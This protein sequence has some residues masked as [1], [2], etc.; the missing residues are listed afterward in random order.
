MKLQNLDN[1]DLHDLHNGM[2]PFSKSSSNATLEKLK[3][4]LWFQILE[5]KKIYNYNWDGG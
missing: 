1:E 3:L 5:I 4:F 2:I